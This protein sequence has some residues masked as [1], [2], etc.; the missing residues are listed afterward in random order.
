[1]C[2]TLQPLLGSLLLRRLHTLPRWFPS[3]PI[4][5]IIQLPPV[6]RRLPAYSSSLALP[7]DSKPVSPS[8]YWIS[9]L[10][11]LPGTWN[12][13]EITIFR[14]V[15]ILLLG[16]SSSEMTPPSI[17]LP[18]S[19]AWV[20]IYTPPLYFPGNQQELKNSPPKF[21]LIPCSPSQACNPHFLCIS[22][23]IS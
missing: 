21:L 18:D 5:S 22:P 3:A 16:S 4:S 11:C 14:L 12:L 6:C 9:S 2:T 15:V 1:M 7:P 8:T 23:P 20:G 10:G 17:Q 13:I 19:E